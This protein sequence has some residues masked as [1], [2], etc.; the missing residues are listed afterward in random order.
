[1]KLESWMRYLVAA[2]LVVLVGAAWVL[3]EEKTVKVEV[4]SDDG[5]EISIDVNGV[6]EIV[7]L[8]DLAEGEERKIDVGGHEMTVKRID[9]RLTLVH[10]GLIAEHLHGDLQKEIVVDV[11]EEG[12]GER[13]MV[14]IKRGDGEPVD[15][16]KEL[17]FIGKG[18][19]GAHEVFIVKSEGGEVDIEALKEKYGDHFQHFDTEH[20]A[21]VMTWVSEDDAE[22]PILIKRV[23][24]PG[25]GYVT[26]RCEETGS[27]LTVKADEDLLDDYV[28][29]VTGCIMKRVERAD[30]RVITIRE[31]HQQ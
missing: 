12:A 1:M 4:Q 13:R 9:N 28:D 3:A 31:K 10:E 6:T 15:L 24:H 2:A 25:D 22:H 14:I 20:G 19:P 16:E 30:V 23:G 17:M 21:H 11:G 27:M 29:P 7:T 26:Y 8:D 18:D 5:R